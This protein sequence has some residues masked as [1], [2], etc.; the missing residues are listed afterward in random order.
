M[1]SNLSGYRDLALLGERFYVIEPERWNKCFRTGSPL[2]R[3]QFLWS[4]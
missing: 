3:R 2:Q 4:R 1:A